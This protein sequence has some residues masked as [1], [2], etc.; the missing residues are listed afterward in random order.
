M[1]PAVFYCS[2][3]FGKNIERKLVLPTL[4][5]KSNEINVKQLGSNDAASDAMVV[6]VSSRPIGKNLRLGEAR[7]MRSKKFEEAYFLPNFLKNFG[8]A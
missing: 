6:F 7:S 4:S 8:E 3:H 2:R 5:C 1:F